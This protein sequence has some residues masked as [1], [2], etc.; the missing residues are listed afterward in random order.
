MGYFPLLV[1][2]CSKSVK[3]I[4]STTLYW[5]GDSSLVSLFPFLL[6]DIILWAMI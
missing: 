1:C 2:I 3:E 6:A 5:V 4:G